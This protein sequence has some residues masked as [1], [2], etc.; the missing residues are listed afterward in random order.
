MLSEDSGK[1]PTKN[2]IRDIIKVIKYLKNREIL[3]KGNTR[4]VTSQEG[5]FLNFLIPLMTTGLPL[6]K[7]ILMT[8]AKSVL[9]PFGLSAGI[10]ATDSLIQKKIYESGTTELVIS[11]KK[12]RRKKI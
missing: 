6:M 5:G 7:S 10:A 9:L 12:G 8:L 1:I 2:E 3:L 4:K 11:N